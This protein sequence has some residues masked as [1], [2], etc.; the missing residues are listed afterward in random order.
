[1]FKNVIVGVDEHQGGPDAIALGTRLVQQT[2]RA[3]SRSR[4]SG[5]SANLGRSDEEYAARDRA[6]AN[7]SK[8]RARLPASKLGS[9]AV[10]RRR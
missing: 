7:S 9:A 6:R 2:G 3:H 4:L 1:M 5:R 8:K 10:A